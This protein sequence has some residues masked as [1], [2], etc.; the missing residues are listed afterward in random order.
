MEDNLINNIDLTDDEVPVEVEITKSNRKPGRRPMNTEKPYT[1]EK[2]LLNCLRKETVTVRFIK[3]DSGF[4]SN[5]KH[6][7]FGGLA[8]NATQIFTVPLLSNGSYKNVLTDSEKEYLETTM[9]LEPN[10]LSIYL[11]TGNYWD[12]FRVRLTKSDSY[13]DLSVPTDY[14]KYKVLLANSDTIAESLEKFSV[15]PKATYKYVLISENDEMQVSKDQMTLSMEASELFGTISNNPEVL[16]VIIETMEGKPISATTKLD[17]LKT[18]VFRLLN[19]NPKLFLNITKD[20]YFKTKILVKHCVEHGLIKKRGDFYYLAENS[21]PLC[22]NTE[23]PV[24]SNVVRYLNN[25]AKQELM[26]ML[27]A[28]LKPLKQ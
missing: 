28:K 1:E 27:E 3:R 2:P 13:L 21:A 19:N 10:A 23:E 25:P 8:E 17:Y 5:P 16:R 14:I 12:D 26:L 24:L 15:S 9:G 18:Q 4:I 22:T 20:P 7:L 11:K 6:I